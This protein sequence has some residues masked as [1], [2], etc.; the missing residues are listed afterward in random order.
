MKENNYNKLKQTLISLILLAVCCVSSVLAQE[1]TLLYKC[2]NYDKPN[3]IA[4][5]I[6]V[7]VTDAPISDILN[8]FTD[9]F[10]CD[11]V[12][13][14]KTAQIRVTTILEDV[15][16]NIAL[17]S[18]LESKD[19]ALKRVN[20]S[21]EKTIFRVGNSLNLSGMVCKFPER[22]LNEQPLYTKTIHVKNFLNCQNNPKCKQTPIILND[23]HNLRKYIERRISKQGKIEVD[24]ASQSFTITD[25]SENVDA[26][27]TLITLL[28]NQAFYNELEKAKY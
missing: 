4:E 28:D 25:I 15:P 20:R 16:W 17:N 2:E 19:L 10:G 24:Y 9:E 18:I 1:N 21:E 8:Y 11:F 13:D 5:K 12:I 7:Y 23:F 26:L 27:M 22:K 3:L 6:N 14:E